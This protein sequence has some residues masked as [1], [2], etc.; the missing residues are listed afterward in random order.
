LDLCKILAAI[1]YLPHILFGILN[2]PQQQTNRV[3][4][5]ALTDFFSK[6]SL[7]SKNFLPII[8]QNKNLNQG[9]N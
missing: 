1:A 9:S 3:K 7:F 2:H 5:M 8:C 6:I 4:K